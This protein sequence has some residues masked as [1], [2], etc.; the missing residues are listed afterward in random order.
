MWKLRYKCKK[1]KFCH[2][3]NSLIYTININA[4]NGSLIDD[5]KQVNEVNIWERYFCILIVCCKVMPGGCCFSNI[6]YANKQQ[7]SRSS[8]QFLCIIINITLCALEIDI[9][10]YWNN[11][12]AGLACSDPVDSDQLWRPVAAM[13]FWTLNQNEKKDDDEF[14]MRQRS[15]ESYVW[16]G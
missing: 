4:K 6:S 5:Q 7:D 13:K 14:T 12:E 1:T 2:S 16:S 10:G 3:E 15:K 11:W 9:L 8:L